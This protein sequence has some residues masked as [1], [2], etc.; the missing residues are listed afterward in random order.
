MRP[1]CKV[2]GEDQGKKKPSVAEA[3]RKKKKGGVKAVLVVKG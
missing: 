3:V 1:I 2:P